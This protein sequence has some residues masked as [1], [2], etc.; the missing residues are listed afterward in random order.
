MGRL[1]AIDFYKIFRTKFFYIIGLVLV[2]L[3][4]LSS[5]S[6][7]QAA[8]KNYDMVGMTGGT[9]EFSKAAWRMVFLNFGN[10]DMCLVIL[11]ILFL[12]SEF[13]FGTMK[14]IATKGYSRE[15]IYLSKFFVS[16]FCMAIYLILTVVTSLVTSLFAGATRL[17]DFYSFPS[18]IVMPFLFSLLFFAVYISLALMISSLIRKSGS[19]LAIYVALTL[20]LNIVPGLLRNFIFSTF[21]KEFD[22]SKYLYSGCFAEISQYGYGFFNATGLP[23]ENFARYLCVGLFFLVLTLGVGIY[24]FREKDI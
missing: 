24:Y 8:L 14:N 21:N 17:T 12:C 9:A 18:N 23:S 10:M 2:G 13:S 4:V 19:A 1:I 6:F 22:L 16:L 11:T 7:V 3:C 5:V 20:V 15:S